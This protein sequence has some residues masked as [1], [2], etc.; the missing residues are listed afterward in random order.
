MFN[1]PKVVVCRLDLFSEKDDNLSDAHIHS[2]IIAQSQNSHL[3]ALG[4]TL[5]I[6]TSNLP[7]LKK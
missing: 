4:T 3:L 5:Y 1:I 7:Y 6:Y 2:C